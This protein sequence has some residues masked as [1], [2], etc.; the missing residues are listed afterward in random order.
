MGEVV[1]QEVT[2][3]RGV[4]KSEWRWMAQEWWSL[5]GL[6]GVGAARP[7]EELGVGRHWGMGR[8]GDAASERCGD[9]LLEDQSPTPDPNFPLPLSSLGSRSPSG[10]CSIPRTDGL[11]TLSLQSKGGGVGRGGWG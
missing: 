11:K 8:L 6:F 3:L 9:R 10:F 4:G 2:W 7:A 1:Q 5:G